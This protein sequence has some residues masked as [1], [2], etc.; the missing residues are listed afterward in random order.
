MPISLS[1]LQ[2]RGIRARAGHDGDVH[3]LLP[4]DLVQFN[5]R[6]NR[7]VGDAQ[8]V[9]AAPVERAR[10]TSPR[11]S[12][13]RGSVVAISRSKNSYIASRRSVTRQPMG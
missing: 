12:R 10:A 7:L 3:A 1:K 6:E 9:I 2:R 11:K 4:F 5:L 8:R 13:M